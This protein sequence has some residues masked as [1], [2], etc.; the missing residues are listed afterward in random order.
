MFFLLNDVILNID[1]TRIAPPV[2]P[3]HFAAMSL[4]TVTKL[5]A[6]LYAADPLLHQNNPERAKRLA[7]LIQAKAPAINAALFVAPS[8]N[9][10]LSQVQSRYAQLSFEVMGS[11]YARQQDGALTTVAADKEVWR[12]LA[13]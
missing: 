13:A 12:R 10:A 2:E 9:C 6:E 5:G 1:T 4:D 11:L 8:P 3:R 7:A